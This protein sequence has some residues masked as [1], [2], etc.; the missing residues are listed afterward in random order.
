MAE[1]RMKMK[2]R[3]PE[4]GPGVE[5]LVQIE[6]PM[7]TGQRMDKETKQKIPAHY[8]QKVTLELN[9]KPMVVVDCGPGVSKDPLFIFRLTDAKVGDTVRISWTDNRGEKGSADTGV[10]I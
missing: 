6:H 7:E 10:E 5:V 8:I 2:T 4:S 1:R 3:A 9:G